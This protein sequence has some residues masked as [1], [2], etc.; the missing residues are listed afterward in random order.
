MDTKK[1]YLSMDVASLKKSL[2]YNLR[3]LSGKVPVNATRGDW[4][5]A[6]E[7]AIRSRLVE[8][9]I[10]SNTMYYEQDAKMIHYMS[11]EFLIGR[12][13]HNALQ[14]LDIDENMKA[15]FKDLAIDME[16]IAEYEPDAALGNGG[17]G[18]LA[19]C[20]LDSMATLNIP[21]MGYGLRYE[22]GM[23]KQEIHD[24]Y[25][26][27]TPDY[28]LITRGNPW[29]FPRPEVQFHVRY[30]GRIQQENGRIRWVDT[31]SVLAMAYDTIIPGYNTPCA[32]TLRLWSAKAASEIDLKDFNQGDY[33]GAV[34]AKNMSENITRV[35]YPDDSTPHGRELRLRQEYFFVSAS[36][37]DMLRRYEMNHTN[38][39]GLADRISIHLNDT[40]PVLAVPELMRI[41]IDEKGLTWDKAWSL[42]QRIFSY[43]NHTL[44]SEALETWPLD[45]IGRI[46]PRHLMIIFDINSQFLSEVSRKFNNDPELIRRVSLIDET[47]GRR[48]RMAYLAVVASHKINGVSKLHSDLMVESIFADFAKIFPERF[49]N[50]TN[51]ITPRRWVSQANEELSQLI[52]SKI[53][54]DWRVHFE[55]L[56]QLEAFENNDEFLTTFRRIK[57]H[58]KQRLA[59]W[60]RRHLNV[61]IN[62]DSLFDIQIKRIHEYKRQLMNVLHVIT[63]YNRIKANP[64]VN[65]VPRTVIFAGKAAS[66]YQ[67]AKDIIKLIN[68]VAQKI[69]NDPVIGDKLKVVFIPNYGVSLAEVII[70]AADLSEQISTAGME[71]SGTGNMKFAANGALTIGTLDGANIEILEKVGADN[72]FI[73][74]NTAEQIKE[75]SARYNPRDIYERNTEL[76]QALDQIRDGF[77]SPE[78]LGLFRPIYDSLVNYGD[79]FMLLADYESYVATHDQ[80]DALYRQPSRWDRKALHNVA[81]MGFF[82]S[83]RAISD[84]V[85]DIWRATPLR[86]E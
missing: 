31:H 71:A 27:E 34:E 17:L 47:G 67:M 52:D 57:S 41:L 80:V 86:F 29:E 49:T 42:T 16:E 25:Q 82:S 51:G 11:M 21:N 72:I 40:H 50:V 70:P 65:W 85:R 20:F 30:G 4:L 26:V 61:N 68:N 46:L 64:N 83:D 74:G 59:N 75:L 60:V 9:W 35:L 12:T 73:F 1:K 28:W 7:L 54:K 56:K 36:M 62:P 79:R 13:F 48:V 37:Q 58:N 44:M 5:L 2:A 14:A 76:K 15:A 66:A 69:N 43:T 39:D 23:F 33:S 19:A 32:T 77:F 55:Q 24:G 81:N 53:G 10:E 84:Y 63:R 3:F 38:L 6:A 18:R 45:L 22:Y 8:R 78:N